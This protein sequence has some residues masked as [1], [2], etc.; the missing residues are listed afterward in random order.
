[1]KHI[2]KKMPSF[3]LIFLSLIIIT[4]NNIELMKK[5][6]QDTMI[7]VFTVNFMG[8]ITDVIPRIKSTLVM[9][10]PIIF[11]TPSFELLFFAEAMLVANS[12]M[13]VPIA[14]TIKPN[15]VKLIL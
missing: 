12:G 9:L 2:N 7:K 15:R 1:M 6:I 3:L 4:L 11:P 8:L 14:I 5:K 10:L 13:L